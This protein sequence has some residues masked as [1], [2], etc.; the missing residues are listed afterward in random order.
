MTHKIIKKGIPSPRNE[1]C[2]KGKLGRNA[3]CI[4]C[5]ETEAAGY[6][7]GSKTNKEGPRGMGA[8]PS[9]IR[10]KI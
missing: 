3:N 2:P 1:E 9:L 7:I 4:P 10:S 5:P 8:L 6:I